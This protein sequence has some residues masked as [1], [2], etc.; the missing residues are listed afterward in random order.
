MEAELRSLRRPSGESRFREWVRRGF[1]VG[2]D[3]AEITNSD[4]LWHEY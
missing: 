1:N 4:Q 2:F 3:V